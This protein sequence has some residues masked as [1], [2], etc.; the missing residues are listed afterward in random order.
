MI[1]YQWAERTIILSNKKVLKK[2]KL[3]DQKDAVPGRRIVGF[4]KDIKP[5][6]LTVR[7]GSGD[8]QVL[9][10]VLEKHVMDNRKRNWTESFQV[11]IVY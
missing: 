6:G 7:F 2:Q 5:T 8:S 3:F 10:K 9:G 1:G 4:V 11:I